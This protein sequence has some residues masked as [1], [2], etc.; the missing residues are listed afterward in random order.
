MIVVH[1]M[2]VKS[3]RYHGKTPPS[4]KRKESQRVSSSHIMR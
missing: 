4:R 3:L 1:G 2:P